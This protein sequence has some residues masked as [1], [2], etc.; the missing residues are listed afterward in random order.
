MLQQL[1]QAQ[2]V[3]VSRLLVE[4]ALAGERGETVSE[5]RAVLTELF[6]LH[7]LVGGIANNVNQV[8]KKLHGTGEVPA[9]SPE[10]FELA[11]RTCRRIEAQIDRLAL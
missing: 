6:A 2:G 11:M 8:T 5:R 9:G 1:A 3:T 10:L 4:S 7:R